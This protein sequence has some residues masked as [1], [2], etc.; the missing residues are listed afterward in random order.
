MCR[1][2]SATLEASWNMD[3][4]MKN[5]AGSRGSSSSIAWGMPFSRRPLLG[6]ES[7]MT[8]RTFS[9]EWSLGNDACLTENVN[10]GGSPGALSEPG[11]DA[12]ARVACAVHGSW[13]TSD[14]PFV[15]SCTSQPWPE[16]RENSTDRVSRRISRRVCNSSRLCSVDC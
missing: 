4:E 14:A 2:C 12:A 1:L 10:F 15:D 16:G 7:S 5:E 6:A 9:T 8:T 11:E 13:A 3:W